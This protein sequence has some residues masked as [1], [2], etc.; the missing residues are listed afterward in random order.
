MLI[1]P[2]REVVADA[3]AGLQDR[4][5]R[6]VADART[7]AT[8]CTDASL[9]I[10]EGI[11]A[12]L[13]S[14]AL[15]ADDAAKFVLTNAAAT[16]LTGYSRRELRRLSMWQ[17]TPGGH[18]REAE[19]LWRAFLQQREQTGA[20]IICSKSGNQ[21]LA[22]YAAAAHVLPGLHVSLLDPITTRT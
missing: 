11:V 10:L 14:A 1:E 19:S 15:V 7:L 20:Y 13:Q 8:G 5:R 2:S 22:A 17:L 16:E 6:L 21:T 3:V 18:E 12:P 4:L 9:H